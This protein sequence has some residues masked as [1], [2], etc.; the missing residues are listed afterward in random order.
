MATNYAEHITEAYRSN[1]AKDDANFD[2]DVTK[3]GL[4]CVQVSYLSLDATDGYFLVYGSL[5]G[6]TFSLYDDSTCAMSSASGSFEIEIDV[7]CQN[8]IRFSYVSGSNATGSYDLLVK[9]E[10]E[11]QF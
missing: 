4:I 11:Y 9:K 1:L 6:V 7:N 5:D 10:Y 2:I 8:C 3:C